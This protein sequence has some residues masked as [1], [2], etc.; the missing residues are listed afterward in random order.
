MARP[1]PQGVTEDEFRQA[2]SPYWIV[3]NVRPALLY[4]NAAALPAIKDA[5]AELQRYV[6]GDQMKM[7]GFLLS[8]HKPG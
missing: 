8:A 2:V 7:P 3:D 4:A 1:G 6:D 5:R